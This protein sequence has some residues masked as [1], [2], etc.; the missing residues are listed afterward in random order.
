MMQ[1]HELCSHGRFRESF[2]SFWNLGAFLHLRE[3]RFRIICLTATMQPAHIPDIMRRLSI[4]KMAVFRKSCFRAG[5][6]FK[7]D[8]SINTENGV[9][10]RAAS[11]ASELAKDGKV[12]VFACTIKICDMVVHQ[13]K[14]I[15][16]GYVNFIPKL[17]IVI[18]LTIC[19]NVA[20]AKGSKHVTTDHQQLSITQIQ[21]APII[22]GTSCMGTGTDVEAVRNV[23]IVGL[24]Y[25]VEQ[26]VQWAGRCRGDGVVT[27]IVQRYQLREVTELSSKNPK[28]SI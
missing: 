20:V 14:Q 21:Q 13:L 28:R 3:I 19:R 25:S 23:I 4:S 15:Q 17:T 7:F 2:D 26:L 5:L 24:P 1:V 6:I 12:L 27:T 16:Q 9:I 10:E 11:L 18:I 22:V 8:T